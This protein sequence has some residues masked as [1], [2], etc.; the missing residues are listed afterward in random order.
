MAVRLLFVIGIAAAFLV[1]AP[2][3]A[4]AHCHEPTA[5]QTVHAAV[6]TLAQ[7]SSG[8]CGRVS[9]WGGF[10]AALG[11]ALSAATYGAAGA[12]I[13]GVATAWHGAA[14]AVSSTASNAA[15]S[16]VGTRV[17]SLVSRVSTA[18]DV[19]SLAKLHARGVGR[20]PA[21]RKEFRAIHGGRKR[22]ERQAQN[23]EAVEKSESS[24][25]QNRSTRKPQPMKRGEKAPRK[26]R[27]QLRSEAG[28][29]KAREVD[30][31]AG[32]VKKAVRKF[33]EKI[34]DQNRGRQRR[35]TEEA[36][37]R[38]IQSQDLLRR[39]RLADGRCKKTRAWWLRRRATAMIRKAESKLDKSG[40]SGSRDKTE[41]PAQHFG[42]TR[43]VQFQNAHAGWQ[44]GEQYGK[45]LGEGV[46]RGWG[47]NP[48]ADL[49]VKTIENGAATVG[50]VRSVVNDW[51]YVYGWKR[52]SW[53][54]AYKRRQ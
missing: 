26:S 1:L 5:Y 35:L 24:A 29:R 3:S 15:A 52:D 11:V 27:T 18:P 25:S 2:E 14:Y 22:Q 53:R 16:R 23:R 49:V 7:G 54:I 20:P 45:L 38:A 40:A 51:P 36:A 39:A 33:A 47:E 10:L 9:R 13:T 37:R 48:A 8:D 4:S 12:L 50:A 6:E 32:K 17:R 28:A 43:S 46:K 21:N 44:R 42:K 34:G 31:R 19:N 41:T 30:K